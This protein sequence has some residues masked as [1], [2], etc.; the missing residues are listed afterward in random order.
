[1]NIYVGIQENLKN[2][3]FKGTIHKE[4]VKNS[5][6]VYFTLL[7]AKMK[8]LLAKIINVKSLSFSYRIYSYKTKILSYIWLTF[9]A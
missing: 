1:M 9:K 4:F 5:Y 6:Y 2:L 7:N 8:N 3:L